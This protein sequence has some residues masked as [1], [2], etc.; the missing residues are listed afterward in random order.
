MTVKF[1][2]DFI[3]LLSHSAAACLSHEHLK[4]HLILLNLNEPTV[5]STLAI[6]FKALR[7]KTM[8]LDKTR[9]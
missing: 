6:N 7:N 3:C 2:I 4:R 1:V 9:F 5:L 8:G